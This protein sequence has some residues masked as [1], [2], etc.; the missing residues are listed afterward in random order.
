[1]PRVGS[2]TTKNQEAPPL[3]GPSEFGT[4]ITITVSPDVLTQDGASQSLVTITA[5]DQNGSRCATC[6]CAPRSSSNGATC[7]FR[8]AVGAKPRDRRQR[9]GHAGV[10]RAGVPLG[11]VGRQ[12]H[13]VQIVVTPVGTD[14][15]NTTA[16]H[17]VDPSRAAGVVVPPDGSAADFT[18]SPH[19][20]DRSTTG[21]VVRRVHERRAVRTTRSR[22]TPGTSATA[23]DRQRPGRDARLRQG[24]QRTSSR[25]TITDFVG[26]SA[27]TTRPSSSAWEQG[28]PQRSRFR[29]RT[30]S[31]C[32]PVSFNA[33]GSTA[34]AG[35]R[36]VNYSWDFGDG[37]PMVTRSS[38]QANK[39]L[40]MRSCGTYYRHARRHRRRRE[41]R[42]DDATSPWRSRTRD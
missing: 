31:R 14:F 2:C 19:G 22:A 27:R 30:R 35:R 29:R 6:R 40:V 15:G 23:R 18:F 37:T 16:R 17:G 38:P 28:R 5:R 10:H 7:R 25:L 21:R 3:T 41:N 11:S 4:S 42:C 24:R 9:P 1:M 20:A 39:R 26:R 12:R 34:P 36:I 32:Q 8:V 13:V 33:S